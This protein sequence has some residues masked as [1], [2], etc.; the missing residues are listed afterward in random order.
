[1]NQYLFLFTLSPVQSFI[2]QARKTQD[3]YTGS[4]ILSALIKAG[5]AEFDKKDVIFPD[6]EFLEENKNASAP[7]RFIALWEGKEESSLQAK[8]DEVEKRVREHFIKM[9]NGV[10][11]SVKKPKGFDQQIEQHLSIYWAFQPMVNGDYGTA[12]RK[13][14][15]NLASIKNIRPFEQY[16]Y[17][18][19]IGEQGR[20]CSLDG[21]RNALFFKERIVNGKKRKPFFVEKNGATLLGG[22]K[23]DNLDF[24]EGLSAV[25]FLKRFYKDHDEKSFPSTA[26]V[27]LLED[28][29]IL[30]DKNEEYLNCLKKVF[31]P[32]Q[33]TQLCLQLTSDTNIKDIN[34]QNATDNPD[35]Q[36]QFDF[37]ACFEENLTEKN[38]PVK[39]QL[40]LLQQLQRQLKS[41]LKTK[42]YALVMFDGD[43]MGKHLGQ[44][45]SSGEEAHK[46]F[47][48]RLSTF[49]AGATRYVNE[50]DRGRAVYAGGD[51]FLGF[52]NINHLFGVMQRLRKMFSKE[53]SQELTFS[54]GIVIAHYKFPLSEVLKNVRS[55]E[56]KAKKNGDRNAFCISTM[57][58]SGEIQEAVFKWG[59]G[60]V[61]WTALKYM[62]DALTEKPNA[63]P[64]FS[65]TFIQNLTI[66]LFSLGEIE[67]IEY[68][69]IVKTEI[70]RLVY[71]SKFKETSR[72]KTMRLICYLI[73]L[74][75]TKVKDIEKVQNFIHALQIAD[76]ISR[77]TRL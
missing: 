56:K 52:I 2:A 17:S 54:A 7:N 61:N 9:A 8:G 24:G 36:T 19:S 67:M 22:Y 31:E 39:G 65:N 12:Y 66:E 30:D 15:I 51:D 45:A 18:G 69:K 70:K 59:K 58:H 57:K 29:K 26:E 13:L 11:G 35:W 74:W 40:H 60:N 20:K 5:V 48:K 16:D 47:S 32:S 10:L 1:M 75:K 14:E 49:A 68:N 73:L 50:K 77:K 33:I 28:V 3:L 44:L 43:K 46:S 25:S 62:V 23:S 37:Q 72:F 76:F 21:E 71:R 42:Y 41:S 27:A 64:A 34:I 55:A 53:V 38:F 4:Y 63:E 6:A